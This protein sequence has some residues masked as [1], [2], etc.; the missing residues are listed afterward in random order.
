M[1]GLRFRLKIFLV[2]LFGIMVVGTI[3]FMIIE[4]ISPIDA[5]YFSIVTIATVGYGDIHPA[6][7]LGKVLA[8]VIIITGVGAFLGVVANSTEMLL[9][10]RERQV[11]M[12]KLNMVIGMFFSE[13]G[14]E[15][16]SFFTETDSQLEEV[17]KRLVVRNNWSDDDFFR[18]KAELRKHKFKVEAQG[19]RLE[20]LRNLLQEKTD[21]LLRLW[22]NPNLLEH[23]AF[24]DLLRALF[25]LEEELLNRDELEEMPE[26]D[27]AHL[28]GDVR[29]AYTLIVPQ[30]LDYM[31]H[32]K[33]HYPYLFSLA[34]RR[35][36]F[37]PQA[38]VTVE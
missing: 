3:G 26:S 2:I 22:E 32:L 7:P 1:D 37:D 8:I 29:R 16:L 34:M 10:R 12:Q 23:E 9:N 11:R 20:L 25:H 18:V 36:P 15:L 30:W 24:T 38:S 14:T 19:L 6:T 21:F 31:R 13:I 17:R 27:I 5:F 35:N 28:A 33:K 4:D